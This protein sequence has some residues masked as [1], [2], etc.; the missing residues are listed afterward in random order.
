MSAEAE[1]PYTICLRVADGSVAL[2]ARRE[3]LRRVAER[4][5]ARVLTEPGPATAWGEIAG[6]VFVADG[7]ERV[8]PHWN[9]HSTIEGSLEAIQALIAWG[10]SRERKVIAIRGAAIARDDR[11]VALVGTPVTGK[12]TLALAAVAAGWRILADEYVV[13]D[14]RTGIVHAYPKRPLLRSQS[15][16]LLPWCRAEA[17]ETALTVRW[18]NHSEVTYHGVDLDRLFGRAVWTSQAELTAI[19]CL[20]RGEHETP[21]GDV[22]AYAAQFARTLVTGSSGGDR[23]VQGLALARGWPCF[24]LLRDDPARMLAALDDHL[25]RAPM[26]AGP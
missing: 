25:Q 12:T 11:C 4:V 19:V 15:L 8:L 10:F 5:Y 6:G 14:P 23:M 7:V 22:A 17:L 24:T 3:D 18:K 26:R 1:S 9:D 20:L 16:A 13:I 2:R 21:P